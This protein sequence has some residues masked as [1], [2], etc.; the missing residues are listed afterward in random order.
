MIS[1]PAALFADVPQCRQRASRTGFKGDPG[2][3]ERRPAVAGSRLAC[4]QYQ[5][6]ES[7][8]AA[9]AEFDVPLQ[10]I[11]RQLAVK[12]EHKGL[13]RV[14]AELSVRGDVHDIVRHAPKL[15][16]K[17]RTAELLVE[18]LVSALDLMHSSDFGGDIGQ[19]DVTLHA[20]R[21]T[22]HKSRAGR[23]L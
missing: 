11:H 1:S 22:E 9:F 4:A 14:V 2:E 10:I 21:D 7:L 12:G 17:T 13:A 15:G 20:F 6:F 8:V 3:A 23:R 19:I 5:Q 18:Q 16:L